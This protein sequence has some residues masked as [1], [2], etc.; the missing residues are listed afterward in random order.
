[1]KLSIDFIK[2]LMFGAVHINY[3]DNN[4]IH[5]DRVEILWV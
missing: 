1:M 2:I 5:T 4:K 3:K